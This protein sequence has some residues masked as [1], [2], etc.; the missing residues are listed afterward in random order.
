M[1]EADGKP[2]YRWTKPLEKTIG[3]QITALLDAQF[4]EPISELPQR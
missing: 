3:Q 2:V 4:L 1:R